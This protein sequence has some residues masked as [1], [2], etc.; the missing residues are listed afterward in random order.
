MLSH[1]VAGFEVD[2]GRIG[3][4]EL[5]RWRVGGGWAFKWMQL[6]AGYDD[7]RLG[8][9]DRAGCFAGVVVRY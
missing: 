5:F 3:D 9:E 8:S 1:A 4:D 6:R 7:Y 2:Y